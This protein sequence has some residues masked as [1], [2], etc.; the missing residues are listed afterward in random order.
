MQAHEHGAQG[1]GLVRTEHMFFATSERIRAVRRM[2]FA[3]DTDDRAAAL[4]PI[5]DFQAHDLQG[6]FEAMAGMPVT[7]RLLDP[8]LH[9]FLPHSDNAVALQHLAEDVG[10][11]VEEV[12]ASVAR[13]REVNPMLG[14]RGCRLGIMYPEVTRMQARC[15]SFAAQ[16]L[17]QP[18][19]RGALCLPWLLQD[20]SMGPPMCVLSCVV[21]PTTCWQHDAK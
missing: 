21:C 3:R 20:T 18:G 13:M 4:K 5:E 11:G 19:L 1:I 14:F 7:I 15:A 12:A 17:Q 16:T 2:I 6:I 8:P 10:M 9:E